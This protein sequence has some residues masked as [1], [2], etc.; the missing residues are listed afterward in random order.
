MDVKIYI[1]IRDKL[2]NKNKE[3]IKSIHSL[4]KLMKHLLIKERITVKKNDKSLHTEIK[5]LISETV[6]ELKKLESENMN[7]EK[8]IIKLRDTYIKK[9][10]SI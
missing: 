9:L 5:D 6:Q 1:D 7:T 3:R 10:N 8:Q 4:R 2:L